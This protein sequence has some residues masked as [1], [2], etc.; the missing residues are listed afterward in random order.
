MPL[1]QQLA[2]SR[3]PEA[4]ILGSTPSVA[5]THFDGNPSFFDVNPSSPSSIFVPTRSAAAR[6]I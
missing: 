3:E 6:S 4:K 1:L 5:R 2:I